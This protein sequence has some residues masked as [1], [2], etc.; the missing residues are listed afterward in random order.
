[1]SP[2]E[3]PKNTRTF[4]KRVLMINICL[5][6]LTA[7]LSVIYGQAEHVISEAFS[8]LGALFAIYTGIG[9]LDYRKAVEL[10][11]DKLVK[12]NGFAK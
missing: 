12:G 10:T 5:I 4:S 3:P 9:H 6:W 2:E 11:I 7:L 1:M 8:L